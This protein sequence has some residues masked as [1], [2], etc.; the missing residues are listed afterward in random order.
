MGGLGGNQ[1]M[2][3][4]RLGAGQPSRRLAD[5]GARAT[6]HGSVRAGLTKY[7]GTERRWWR[8][9]TIRATATANGLKMLSRA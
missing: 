9:G 5:P 7:A 3:A 1:A 2:Y 4:V 6:E 8:C